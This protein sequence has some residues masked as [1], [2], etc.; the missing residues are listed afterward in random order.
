MKRVIYVE[1]SEDGG[2]S[3]ESMIQAITHLDRSH[4][5]PYVL[6]VND[7]SHTKYVQRLHDM[8]VPVFTCHNAVYTKT[9][10]LRRFYLHLLKISAHIPFLYLPLYRLIHGS[11]IRALETLVREHNIDLIHLN[12]SIARDLFG[13]FVAKKQHIP[14]VSHIRSAK[15]LSFPPAAQRFANTYVDQ[16]ITISDFIQDVWVGLGLDQNKC[17][18]VL[19]GIDPLPALERDYDSIPEKEKLTFCTVGRLVEWKNHSWLLQSFK[20]F[21]AIRPDAQLYIVG[22][23]PEREKLENILRGDGLE[24]NVILTGNVEDPTEYL[25]ASDIFV[26]PSR[27]EPFGRAVLEAMSLGMPLIAAQSGGIPEFVSDGESGILVELNNVSALTDAMK[28]LS[29]DGV[30]CAR[31]GEAAKKNAGEKFSSKATTEQIEKVYGN[32]TSS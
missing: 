10:P 22:E 27:K 1:T 2:G 32:V 8:N 20:A 15:M 9:S 26:F 18:T 4:Y 5:E 7:L 24:E 16:F 19:N 17:T 31:L 11:S 29:S 6:F 21:L 23:G 30:L 12:I 25:H 28:M 13:V 14:C 3:S